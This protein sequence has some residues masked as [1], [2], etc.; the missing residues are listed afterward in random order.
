MNCK[1]IYKHDSFFPLPLQI[2]PRSPCLQVNNDDVGILNGE[3]SECEGFSKALRKR[4]H[5]STGST[6]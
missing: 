4:K 1:F 6:S 5:S 3:V 2:L